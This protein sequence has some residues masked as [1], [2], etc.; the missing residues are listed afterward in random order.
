MIR[1]Y[2]VL[3]KIGRSGVVGII[4]VDDIE[5]GLMAAE[6]IFEGGIPVIEVSMTYRGAHEIMAEMT[7]RLRPKGLLLGAGTVSDP[8]TARMC[9]FAGAEFIFAHCFNPEVARTCNRYGIPY[10][11]GVGTVSEI[12]SALESGVDVVKA[13]PGE[14][15]G[16]KFV[17]AVRGPLPDAKILAVGGV[18]DVNLKDWFDAGVFGVGLGSAL[19]KPGGKTG[20]AEEICAASR[21]TVEII[22]FPRSGRR[23][24]KEMKN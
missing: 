4:R 15:L 5:Y 13:F 16:P 2:E 11:P 19:T 10:I 9:M 8:E 14:V 18:S 22:A 6:A 17:K 21:A 12:M 24:D 7:K 3:E 20:T 1:K 23:L